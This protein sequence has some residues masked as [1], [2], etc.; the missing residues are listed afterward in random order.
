MSESKKEL[1]AVG[2]IAC[3]ALAVSV[4]ALVQGRREPAPIVA[5][6]G[7]GACASAC[8]AVEEARASVER[9]WRAMALREAALAAAGSPPPGGP[10]P[11]P[12]APPEPDA[13]G[14][15]SRSMLSP[16][17][18][19]WLRYTAFK[20]SNPAITIAQR[21]ADGLLDVETSDP[22]LAGTIVPVT[23]TTTDGKEIHLLVKVPR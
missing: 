10:S 8:A 21:E 23:A 13:G 16:D 4:V 6:G 7:P 17:A 1:Y 5:S 14:A 9:I 11:P 22:A 3:A 18:G 15:A 2:A 20:V 12:E 19:R